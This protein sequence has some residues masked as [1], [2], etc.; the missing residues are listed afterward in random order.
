MTEK[1]IID[2]LLEKRGKTRKEM[3]QEAGLQVGYSGLCKRIKGIHPWTHEDFERLCDYLQVPRELI[4]AGFSVKAPKPE[5]KGVNCCGRHATP[6][7][8]EIELEYM[9]SGQEIEER[10]GRI[11]RAIEGIYNRL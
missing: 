11:E 3:S 4:E 9:S 5:C 10:L 1:T 6:Q 7:Q 2:K 8:T